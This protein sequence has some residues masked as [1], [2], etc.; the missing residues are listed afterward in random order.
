MSITAF[1]S[2]WKN[3][4]S[5]PLKQQ[6]STGKNKFVRWL[7]SEG[8]AGREWSLPDLLAVRAIGEARSLT[9]EAVA[10][11]LQSDVDR[12]RSVLAHLVDAGIVEAR[13]EG[14]GRA[15]HLTAAMY[16]VLGNRAGYVRVRGFEPAQQEQM[17][18]QYAQE[19]GQITR[20]EAAELCKLSADQASRLLR[21]LAGVTRRTKYRM[22]YNARIWICAR[23]YPA[24]RDTRI[25]LGTIRADP[26]CSS[27][28]RTGQSSEHTSSAQKQGGPRQGN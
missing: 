21:R 10:V 11:A 20:R 26:L 2:R 15:Y 1:P 14:R 8:R 28:I 17:V 4:S 23:A 6:C 13:G 3:A 22:R 9:A 7:V 24:Q 25:V 16:R 18:L 5:A 12:A 19:H 27:K